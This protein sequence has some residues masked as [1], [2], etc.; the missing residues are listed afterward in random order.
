[1]VPC[2]WGPVTGA[3]ETGGALGL[4]GQSLQAQGRTLS[5][6]KFESDGGRH[7]VSA[8]GLLT[9]KHTLAD[10]RAHV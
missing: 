5:Q 1:M 2:A 4:C 6:N 9:R 3:E 10:T 8:S 7:A